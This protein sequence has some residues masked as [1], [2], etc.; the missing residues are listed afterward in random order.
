M[1]LYQK[2]R[3]AAFLCLSLAMV[4]ISIVRISGGFFI[5]LQGKREISLAWANMLLHIEAG[6][7]VLM[8]SISAFRAVFAGQGSPEES[9]HPSLIYR[10][11]KRLGL[12]GTSSSGVVEQA[13]ERNWP[14]SPEHTRATLVSLREFIRRHNRESG[15]TTLESNDDLQDPYHEFIRQQREDQNS[16]QDLWQSFRMPD[17]RVEGEVHEAGPSLFHPFADQTYQAIELVPYP[18][19]HIRR[20]A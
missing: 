10:I 19:A 20:N 1:R 5:N 18:A 4:I 13:D 2:I 15:H 6:V 14:S 9:S 8:G 16:G 11:M 12:Y 7:A 3:I 17:W